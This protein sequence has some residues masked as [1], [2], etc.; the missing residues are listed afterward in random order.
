MPKPIRETTLLP[1]QKDYTPSTIE[2]AKFERYVQ[3]VDHPLSVLE[4]FENG[5]VTR[6]H[7]EA[8]QEVYPK[9][10]QQV[11]QTAFNRMRDVTDPLPYNKVIQL[12]ILLNLPG[13]DS[14]LGK[15]IKAL[16]EN[17]KPGEEQAAAGQPMVNSTQGGAAE[18]D[19]AAREAS[20]TQA[21]INRRNGQ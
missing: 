10:Y 17:L 6:E 12:S 13:D 3:A 7:I 11:R 4:D 1:N 20:D 21:F 15:N 14:L 9:L 2:L 8:I 18:V 16:Q 19:M 5:T